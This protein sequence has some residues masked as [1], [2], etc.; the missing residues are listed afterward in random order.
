[1]SATRIYWGAKERRL[2]IERA[3]QILFNEKKLGTAAETSA[4]RIA[5]SEVL[6]QNRQRII[7][8]Y[9][10]IAP[11][12]AR[13]VQAVLDMEAA[14]KSQR[15]PD[16]TPEPSAEKMHSVMFPQSFLD[17]I[18]ERIAVRVAELITKQ[19]PQ[20]KP[21]VEQNLVKHNPFPTNFGVKPA[22]G[23]KFSI[24]IFG[25]MDHQQKTLVKRFPEIIFRFYERALPKTMPSVDAMVG[26][27]GFMRHATDS[28]LSQHYGRNY[29]RLSNGMSQLEDKL[30]ALYAS[31]RS[32]FEVKY[33]D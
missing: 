4:V 11:L 8:G 32:K 9:H 28:K 15:V 16:A 1:M 26:M 24:G 18:V 7:T 20:M 10:N 25:V 31:W 5:Q 33:A 29:H 3:A 22:P 21:A 2:I 19:E 12:S 23:S 6:P 13:I 30:N 27:V 14:S 17:D